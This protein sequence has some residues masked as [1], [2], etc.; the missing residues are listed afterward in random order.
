MQQNC[1]EHNEDFSKYC[2]TCHNL[3]CNQCA[4][5]HTKPPTSH[6]PP[7]ALS[8]LATTLS[9]HRRGKASESAASLLQLEKAAEGYVALAKDEGMNLRM[10]KLRDKLIRLDKARD[11]MISGIEGEESRSVTPA[12]EARDWAQALDGLAKSRVA[13][14]DFLAKVWRKDR[15]VRDALVALMGEANSRLVPAG[16]SAGADVN[17][18]AKEED[19]K[20]ERPKSEDIVNEILNKMGDDAPQET[21]PAATVPRPEEL[22]L[23]KLKQEFEARKAEGERELAGI[24]GRIKSESARLDAEIALKKAD[25]DRTNEALTLAQSGV[26]KANQELAAAESAAK[27]RE[28]EKEKA[29]AEAEQV[30]EQLKKAKDELDRILSD[31]AKVKADGEKETEKAKGELSGLQVELE[32]ARTEKEKAENE[33]AGAKAEMTQ[34]LAEKEKIAG[35]LAGLK[36]EAE[37]TNTEK[38]KVLD[39]LGT[40][41]RELT[42]IQD[43][44]RKTSGEIAGLKSDLAGLQ[45]ERGKISEELAK[46]REEKTRLA[47][48]FEDIKDSLGKVHAEK[49]AAE[50]ARDKAKVA[51][52]IAQKDL[53]KIKEELNAAETTRESQQKTLD[54][55]KQAV[56]SRVKA[57]SD[58]QDLTARLVGLREEVK[59][60][61]ARRDEVV[62]LESRKSELLE[63]IRSLEESQTKLNAN[64]ETLISKYFSDVEKLKQERSQ[65]EADV[66]GQREAITQLGTERSAAEKQLVELRRDL[67]LLKEEHKLASNTARNLQKAESTIP[68]LPLLSE[69]VPRIEVSKA[70]DPSPPEGRPVQV[71]KSQAALPVL[72]QDVSPTFAEKR[73]FDRKTVA[74]TSGS[75][76]HAARRDPNPFVKE[77][78]RRA[79]EVKMLLRSPVEMIKKRRPISGEQ[80]TICAICQAELSRPALTLYCGHA[81][82]DVCL[83]RVR[84]KIGQGASNRDCKICGISVPIS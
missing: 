35:E 11:E 58:L 20:A 63:K 40:A 57:E 10:G 70:E 19:K 12:I 53:A 50:E 30:G 5:T 1:K 31:V 62:Q 81:G 27:V 39:S 73:A 59:A 25:L 26:A 18:D 2:E 21:V 36:T 47:G 76:M 79:E 38:A 9:A 29:A 43:E 22:G 4:D 42:Q 60:S 66:S 45:A 61:E 48:E 37:R 8:D 83:G 80:Q 16:G 77:D 72:V 52:G 17:V 44:T 56:E 6:P 15:K 24:E 23:E 54:A 55:Q 33:L 32:R 67:L 78:S 34:I 41:K 46:V 68:L 64:H 3:L 28:E 71:R 49:V 69:Q 51:L 75:P 65:L 74:N 7:V 13:E 82:C 14:A 84:S